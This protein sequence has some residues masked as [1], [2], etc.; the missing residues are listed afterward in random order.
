MNYKRNLQYVYMLPDEPVDFR[1]AEKQCQAKGW[2][3]A[4]F[5]QDNTSLDVDFITAQNFIKDELP[6]RLAPLQ[7]RESLL[8]QGDRRTRN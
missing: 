2:E 7:Q 1:E 4:S 8:Q 3:L 6:G 5:N